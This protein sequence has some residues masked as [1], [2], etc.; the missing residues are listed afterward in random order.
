MCTPWIQYGLIMFI[1][2]RTHKR[3]C[4]ACLEGWDMRSQIANFMEPTWGP[5]GSCRPQM[6][7]ML[8]PWTL[9][10]GASLVSFK[11][12]L[13]QNCNCIPKTHSKPTVPDKWHK[14][15]LIHH[16][17]IIYTGP[18]LGHHSADY[19]ITCFLLWL[20]R[21]LIMASNSIPKLGQSLPNS[22]KHRCNCSLTCS[23][24][25]EIQHVSWGCLQPNGPHCMHAAPT[26]GIS[27]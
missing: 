6:G 17:I 26:M 7:P 18:K 22:L 20:W 21:H 13:C 14:K 23:L 10:S 8:V 25:A 19:K 4:I 1:T 24:W 27:W 5:P 16:G 12:D 2:W 9:L 15:L 11:Y 3:H